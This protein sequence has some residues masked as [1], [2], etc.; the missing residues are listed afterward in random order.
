VRRRASAHP[1]HLRRR[2]AHGQD[3]S[4]RVPISILPGNIVAY[5][6]DGLRLEKRISKK[7]IGRRRIKE[8][9]HV[10]ETAANQPTNEGRLPN[11]LRTPPLQVHATKRISN[12]RVRRTEHTI[13][14]RNQRGFPGYPSLMRKHGTVLVYQ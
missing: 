7:L 3:A 5:G 11:Q 8:D 12:R 4:R 13:P 10:A 9:E 1:I 14:R 2:D 6:S